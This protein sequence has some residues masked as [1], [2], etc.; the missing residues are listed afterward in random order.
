MLSAF[1][2]RV[3]DGVGAGI[4]GAGNSGAAVVGVEAES[5]PPKHQ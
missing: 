5:T 4:I 3:A 1:V 2:R